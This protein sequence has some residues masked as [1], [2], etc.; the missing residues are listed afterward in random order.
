MLKSLQL[1][2]FL[3]IM[4]ESSRVYGNLQCLSLFQH[5][6]ALKYFT[7]GYALPDI[8]WRPPYTKT[9]LPFQMSQNGDFAL[10]NGLE[11]GLPTLRLNSREQGTRSVL[12]IVGNPIIFSDFIS[13]S[14]EKAILVNYIPEGENTPITEI[15]DFTGSKLHNL[16]F[17]DLT[18][19]LGPRELFITELSMHSQSGNLIATLAGREVFTISQPSGEITPRLSSNELPFTHSVSL[20]HRRDYSVE[21]LKSN[22]H[23]GVKKIDYTKEGQVLFSWVPENAGGVK[24]YDFAATQDFLV[25][26]IFSWDPTGRRILTLDKQSGEFVVHDFESE[27][28]VIEKPPM[29]DLAVLRP[30]IPT[31]AQARFLTRDS[32]VII[33]QT[34]RGYPDTGEDQTPGNTPRKLELEFV[35]THLGEDSQASQR[36]SVLID[37]N[38]QPHHGIEKTFWLPTSQKIVG[39]FGDSVVVYDK[40]TN[41]AERVDQPDSQMDRSHKPRFRI[42]F[43]RQVGNSEI[44]TFDLARGRRLWRF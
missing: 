12:K 10:I 17:S 26:P 39:V 44:E 32:L 15:Y 30:K 36:A 5:V 2:L 41:T 27:T 24:N 13:W 23:E 33:K 16:D 21:A 8:R 4:G 1:L 22:E 34:D 42:L 37:Y 19:A 29:V 31:V 20:S 28:V 38:Q 6:S 18:Q 43:A 25:S 35:V 9:A 40:E 11:K 14:E 7:P 3:L